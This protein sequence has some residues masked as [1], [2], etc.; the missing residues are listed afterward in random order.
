MFVF[1]SYDITDPVRLRRVAKICEAYGERVQKSVFECYLSAAQLQAMR[2]H[3]AR[4]VHDGEDR[5]FVATLCRAD[6]AR[7]QV[8]GWGQKARD[9]DYWMS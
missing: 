1:V 7:I 4:I 2:S 9:W 3:L 8:D 5:L 6:A